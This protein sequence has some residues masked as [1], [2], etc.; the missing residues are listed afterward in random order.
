M[1]G[2]G[3]EWNGMKRNGTERNGTERNGTERKDVQV[4]RTQDMAPSGA[5][6]QKERSSE[7]WCLS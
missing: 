3:T 5:D 6:A 2:N 7:S 1:E 4:V